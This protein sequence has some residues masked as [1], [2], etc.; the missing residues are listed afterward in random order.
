MRA[1]SYIG[2]FNFRSWF[3]NRGI[4]RSP[5][6]FIPRMVRV[7]EVTVPRGADILFHLLGIPRIEMEE[8]SSHVPEEHD[9]G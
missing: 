2:I 5:E 6:V 4:S 7:I 9:R 3:Q 8:A 1:V